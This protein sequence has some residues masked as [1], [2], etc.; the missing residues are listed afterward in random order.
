MQNN[1]TLKNAHILSSRIYYHAMLHGK[2][3]LRLHIEFKVELKISKYI[4][5]T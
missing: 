1:A 5:G 3:E 4:E 2:W